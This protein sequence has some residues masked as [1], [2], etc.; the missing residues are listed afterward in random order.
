MGCSC[1]WKRQRF[2]MDAVCARAVREAFFRLFRDGLIYRGQPARQLGLPAPNRRLGRRDRLRK[3]PGP[4]LA[5]QVSGHRPET[6]RAGVRRRWPRRVP[7]PCSATRPWPSIP[8]RRR[9]WTKSRYLRSGS[10]ETVPRKKNGSKTS[11]NRSRAHRRRGNR[12]VFRQ[13]SQASRHGQRRSAAVLL[14]LLDRPI[15]LILDEWADPA[16]GSGCV[17]ITPGHDP[18]DYDVWRRHRN[19]IGIINILNPNGSLN[20]NAGPYRRAWT[21]SRREKRSRPTCGPA[22]FWSKRSRTARS[23]SAIPTGPRRR[24]SRI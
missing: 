2:T 19:E 24:S 16:L 18:N 17:K 12:L 7:R 6:R 1:D 14:P 5:H 15:P 4:F 20:A 10:G 3:G 8:T 9:L 21:A 11:I 22:A 13:S 23:R